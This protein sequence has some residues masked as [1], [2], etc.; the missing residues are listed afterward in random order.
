VT[1]TFSG[2]GNSRGYTVSWQDNSKNETAFVIE[3]RPAGSTNGWT[4]IATVRSVQLDVSPGVVDPNAAGTGARTYRDTTRSSTLY[5]YQ[6]YAVNVV[7]DVWDYSNPAF[8]EIPPGGGFP[9][10]TLDSRGG[11]SSAV[12]A[13]TGLAGTLTVKSKKAATAA[14]SWNDNSANESGFLIQRA[15]NAGFSLNVVNATVGANLETFSQ[16]VTPGKTF[17]YRVL[18]FNDTHQSG[19][20][21]TVQLPAP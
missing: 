9:T 4:Q 5:E 13:P 11:A 3:R 18:A 1:G 10:L 6:V 16:S 2:T 12:D 19:W 21:N 20:S 7:G 15:D 8:N 14:L 17:Y